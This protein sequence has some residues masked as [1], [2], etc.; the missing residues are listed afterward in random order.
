MRAHSE[1]KAAIREIGIEW[2]VTQCRE[3]MKAGVPV[4][5]FYS[6]GKAENIEKIAK[7]VF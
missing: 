2:A 5:H 7:T 6:M 1:D 4:L 3:L